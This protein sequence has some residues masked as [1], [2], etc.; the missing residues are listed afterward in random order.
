MIE[1]TKRAFLCCR[2]RLLKGL[3]DVKKRKAARETPCRFV[4]AKRS[5]SFQSTIISS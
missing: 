2:V 3:C 1:F 5:V 4:F